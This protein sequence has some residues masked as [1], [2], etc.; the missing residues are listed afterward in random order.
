L[1][2]DALVARQWSVWDLMPS[3]K[4]RRHRLTDF[5]R[6]VDGHLTCSTASLFERAHALD[7]HDFIPGG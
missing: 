3:G 1:I 7:D 2:A 5:A 6:V 4:A